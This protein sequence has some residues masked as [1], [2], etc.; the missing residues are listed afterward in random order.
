M[1]SGGQILHNSPSNWKIHFFKL[2]EKNLCFQINVLTGFRPGIAESQG[3]CISY[4]EITPFT[5]EL[6]HT[7]AHKSLSTLYEAHS[8]LP[9]QRQSPWWGQ[10]TWLGRSARQDPHMSASSASAPRPRLPPVTLR[11]PSLALASWLSSSLT[12]V[13]D[14]YLEANFN[15][16][17]SSPPV[18]MT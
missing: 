17:I 8:S 14:V 12:I 13:L 15:C 7:V 16:L 4:F 11:A 9:L 2:M 3:R 6:H 18:R 5:L 10:N 1:I